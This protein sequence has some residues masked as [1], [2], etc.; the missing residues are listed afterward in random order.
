MPGV[1][2]PEY[3]KYPFDPV[4]R[5]QTL[6]PKMIMAVLSVIRAHM[7]A[8]FP[9]LKLPSTALEAG[10]FTEWN[11][12]VR[13]ALLW[14]GYADPLKS[15]E[16]IRNTDPARAAHE[17]LLALLYASIRERE[18]SVRHI[19]DHLN[20]GDL[21]RFQELTGH[22]PNEPF[23][24]LRIGQFFG[25]IRDRWFGESPQHKLTSSK[26]TGGKRQWRIEIR[27]QE[28]NRDDE[29]AF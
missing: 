6:F 25:R 5:A 1:A 8:G 13:A 15:Q 9:G 11:K 29:E 16:A 10:S 28:A 23:S 4:D 21:P 26:S 22:K 12:W 2:R 7:L 14:M 18:C 24:E 19:K 20:P 27:E 3:Q 17:E